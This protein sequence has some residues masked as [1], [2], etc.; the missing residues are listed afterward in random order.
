MSESGESMPSALVRVAFL[1]SL[2]LLATLSGTFSLAAEVER[3]LGIA[4]STVG[5]PGKRVALVMGNAAYPGAGALKNPANDAR[6]I[7]AKLKKLGF[8]V[9]VRTD[10]RQKDMLRALTEFGEK[11]QSGTE[12]LF[13]Y[14]GHGMQVRGK[15]YLIPIDAEIRTE[16][17]VSSEAVDVDQLLDKLASARLSLVI[18]DAC[19]NNPFERR[20]R[21]SGQGLAQINAPTGTLIAYA[22]APGKVAADGEGRNGLYTAELLSA[23]DV[24]GIRIEDVF[25]RV[26]ANVINRSGDAQTPW[27]S[28]SL[29]GDFYF[30][31]GQPGG[32]DQGG[33]PAKTMHLQSAA[34]VEQ[35]YWNRIDAKPSLAAYEEYLRHYPSGRFETIAR[36]EVTRLKPAGTIAGDQARD[37]RPPES[38][39]KGALKRTHGTEK[40]WLIVVQEPNCPFCKQLEAELDTLADIAIYTHIMAFSPAAA[41][42]LEAILCSANPAMSW[43]NWMRFEIEPTF[44]KPCRKLDL[45]QTAE[46]KRLLEST[47]G[48]PRILFPDGSS[49]NGF[50]QADTIEQHLNK[51]FPR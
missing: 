42:R 27:E 10:V 8:D 43:V 46:V 23:M 25:K 28:S 7:A 30:R 49:T 24:P 2:S 26:R 17:A 35:D 3:N 11:V 13:F 20:F 44:D 6:D 29:T 48:T 38:L 16:S 47:Q 33:V 14:A 41:V 12:A 37:L 39:I 50:V 1:V 45:E 31:P 19:R 32:Q 4:G 18:L 34:E 22:T 36:L 40:R 21:G 51:L 9:T 15:N 5:S